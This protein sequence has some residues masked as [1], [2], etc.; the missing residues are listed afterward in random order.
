[1]SKKEL[2]DLIDALP[3]SELY[4]ARRFLEFLLDQAKKKRIMDAFNRAP[5]EEDEIPPEE[6]EAIKE[7]ESDLE[8]GRIES[9]DKVLK[10]L[11]K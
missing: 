4:P 6:L 7:G 5:E 11:S 8:K 1:M 9:W 10:N 2:Y 3:E